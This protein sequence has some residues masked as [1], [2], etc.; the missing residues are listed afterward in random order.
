[1]RVQ[2][3]DSAAGIV[4]DVTVRDSLGAGDH[5]DNAT[6]GYGPATGR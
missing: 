3:G 1:V 6:L 2:V 4:V 5:E